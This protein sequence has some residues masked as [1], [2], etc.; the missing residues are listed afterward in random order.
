MSIHLLL[1][2]RR[3]APSVSY[4]TVRVHVD[5]SL[6]RRDVKRSSDVSDGEFTVF[7][8]LDV[9]METI[10][11]AVGKLPS[12]RKWSLGMPG[13]GTVENQVSVVDPLIVFLLSKVD[14]LKLAYCFYRALNVCLV[15]VAACMTPEML[16]PAADAE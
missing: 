1:D 7:E 6:C 5:I 2:W 10:R 11:Q 13:S 12:T 9:V 14:A 16:V 8:M 15:A 4:V 3:K